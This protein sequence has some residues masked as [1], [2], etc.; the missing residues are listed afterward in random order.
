[1]SSLYLDYNSLT[2]TKKVIVLMSIG[3]VSRLTTIE[4]A[5][6]RKWEARYGFPVPQRTV[7]GQ[8]GYSQHDI[9]QLHEVLRRLVAGERVGKVMAS[10]GQ[11]VHGLGMVTGNKSQGAEGGLVSAAL[12]ALKASRIEHFQEILAAV[13]LEKTAQ[14]FIEHLAAPLTIAVGEAWQCG[15]LPIYA[16]HYFTR[17]MRALLARYSQSS[18][19][20][21]PIILLATLSGE[22]HTLG[23]AM[24]EAALHENGVETVLLEGGL[25]ISELV[26]AAEAYQVRGLAISASLAF[27]SNLLGPMVAKLRSD[28]PAQISIWLGGSGSQRLCHLPAGVLAISTIPAAIAASQQWL[29]ESLH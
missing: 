11:A 17:S 2:Y 5:T 4:V 18:T 1:M 9:D 27:P 7:G 13:Q 14:D 3:A 12:A 22:Y 10:L 6:L 15:A 20:G 23:I 28:L 26:A 24:L 21:K 25:P 29:G 8:R 19:R 16:E